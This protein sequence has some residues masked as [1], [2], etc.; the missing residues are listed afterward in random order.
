MLGTID[1]YFIWDHGIFSAT[2][3]FQKQLDIS[4][5]GIIPDV[6]QSHAPEELM[7]RH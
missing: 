7:K 5:L 3:K 1:S 4:A 6:S 2:T